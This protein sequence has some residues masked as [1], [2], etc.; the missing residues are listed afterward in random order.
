MRLGRRYD[1][2]LD[3][4]APAAPFVDA[5]QKTAA[6]QALRGPRPT[7]PMT[8]SRLTAAFSRA[9]SQG[10]AALVAYI[11]AGDPDLETCAAILDALPSSGVDVIELGFPFT[12]PMAD[13]PSI[14]RA[15][16]RAL[17]NKVTL[18][19][20][21]ALAAGFRAKHPDTPL[22][23]MG[24]LNPIETMGHDTFAAN[25]TVSG[26][27]GAI[28]VDAPPEEDGELRAAMAK[29]DLALIRLFTPTTDAARMPRVAEGVAGFAYYVSVAGITGDKSIETST[30]EGAVQA[31][32][33]ATDLPV[34]VGFGIKTPAMA[35]EVGRIADGVV[36]GSALVD[37][38]AKAAQSRKDGA[39][40]DPVAA[41]T[42]FCASL[43]SAIKTARA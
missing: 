14:Q 5:I 32:R 17:A 22:I 1:D 41:A 43:A 18:T 3:R 23:V 40:G 10:R 29:A 42:A 39:S 16:I 27:D 26:V 35:A 12:D 38:I 15:G 21:L 2:K 6:Q 37:E 30:L 7:S 19:K 33:A 9:K 24:Y 20:T 31:V 13:G 34:A 25:A 36:V 28:I 4:A 8:T 11:M